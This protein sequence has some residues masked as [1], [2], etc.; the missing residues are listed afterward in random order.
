MNRAAK[1]PVF[2][3]FCVVIVEEEL[4][5][6]PSLVLTGFFLFPPTHCNVGTLTYVLL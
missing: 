2:G 3:S 6:A 5:T 1:T 4:I